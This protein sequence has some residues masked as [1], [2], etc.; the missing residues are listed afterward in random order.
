VFW[1]SAA[2]FAAGALVS[3]LLLPGGAP[4]LE[5]DAEPGVAH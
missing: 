4:E 2:I 5:P 1:W 3:V